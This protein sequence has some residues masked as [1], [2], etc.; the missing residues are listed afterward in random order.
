MADLE[1][2]ATLWR[3]SQEYQEVI[4]QLLTAFAGHL[5]SQIV[6]NLQIHGYQLGIEIEA[7][8]WLLMPFWT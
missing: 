1:H 3:V 7:E 6:S 2:V 5:V 8:S 4:C